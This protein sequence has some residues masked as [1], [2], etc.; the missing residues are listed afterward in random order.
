MMSQKFNQQLDIL[1]EEK[2]VNVNSLDNLA[3]TLMKFYYDLEKLLLCGTKDG[4]T[5]SKTN[6]HRKMNIGKSVY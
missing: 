2:N 3:N 5:F 6:F 1:Q 4:Q